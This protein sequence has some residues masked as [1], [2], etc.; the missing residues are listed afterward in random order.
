MINPRPYELL[1]A[2]AVALLWGSCLVAA[3]LMYLAVA[4]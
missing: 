4:P 3:L 1:A 2:L